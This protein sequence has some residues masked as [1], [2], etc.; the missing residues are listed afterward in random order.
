MTKSDTW[1]TF[2]ALIAEI[3][4]AEAFAPVNTLTTS[5]IGMSLFT[6]L[7]I[8]FVSVIVTGYITTPVQ[9][10]VLFVKNV[11]NGD[12]SRSLPGKDTERKDE[13]GILAR[14]I[15]NMQARMPNR[16]INSGTWSTFFK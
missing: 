5:M 15:T 3:D 11:A 14:A 8:V 10:V 13:I 6:A 9:R 4:T 7:L 16:L 12:F 1:D 2:W